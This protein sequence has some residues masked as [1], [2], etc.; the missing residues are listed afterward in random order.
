MHLAAGAP[1]AGGALL[2]LHPEQ[3]EEDLRTATFLTRGDGEDPSLGGFRFA[4]TSLQEFFLADYLLSG[5]RE[6]RP[7]RWDL[8]VPSVETLDFLGQML[9]LEPNTTACTKMQSW[10]K[11]PRLAVNELLLAYAENAD[12]LGWPAP[13]LRGL[14]LSGG[15]FRRPDL[16]G[17][18]FERG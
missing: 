8:P 4:H 1:G 13:S 14:D 15:R 9:W 2:R 3:L 17:S 6:D 5:A 7:E 12:D 11:A 10:A 18:R 16:H